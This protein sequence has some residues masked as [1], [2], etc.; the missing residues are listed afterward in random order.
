[1]SVVREILKALPLGVAVPM[2]VGAASVRHEDA[3]SNLLKWVHRIGIHDLPDWLTYASTD[4]RVIYASLFAAFVYA[5]VMWGRPILRGASALR[6]EEQISLFEPAT[7]AYEQTRNMEISI[8]AEGLADSSEE[9]LCWYCD[10]MTRCQNGREP[11]VKLFGNRPP[12]REKEEIYMAALSR[13]DFAVEG[14]AIILQERNGALRYE[15][16]SV[17]AK[18]LAPPIPNFPSR[19]V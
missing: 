12:S 15:N 5:V 7:R 19:N 2:L 14:G 11:R 17:R 16:L 3:V 4:R 9:I 10:Q 18:E 8:I 1:M 13:Y 6:E